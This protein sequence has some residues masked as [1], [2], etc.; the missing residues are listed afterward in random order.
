M[1]NI[2]TFENFGGDGDQINESK[3]PFAKE[4]DRSL[5]LAKKIQAKYDDLIDFMEDERDTIL[6]LDSALKKAGIA[7][8][9]FDGGYTDSA[10]FS[11]RDS[12][13]SGWK[14]TYKNLEKLK[15]EGMDYKYQNFRK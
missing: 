1:S 10:I 3:I 2:K 6:E 5:A 9:G 15:S 12:R 7:L 8:H 11:L 14:N 4:L 13:D